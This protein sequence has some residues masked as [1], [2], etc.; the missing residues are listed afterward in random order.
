MAIKAQGTTRGQAGADDLAASQSA[1][2]RGRG[3]FWRSYARSKGAILGAVVLG[4]MILMAVFAT[5]VTPYDPIEVAPQDALAGPTRSH[6]MGTDQYGR[7]VFSR[8]ISG[9]RISLAIGF[10][11]VAIS[12]SVGTCLGVIAGFTENVVDGVIMRFIDMQLAFPG[13]LLAMAIVA[14]LGASTVNVVIAV[15]IGTIPVYARVARGAV[16]SIKR[17]AYIDAGRVIGCSTWRL[18]VRHI[19]PNIVA[20]I[21]VLATIGVAYSIINGSALAFLGLGTQPPDAEWGL[22]ISDGRGYLNDAWWISTFP[23]LAL[24]VVVLAINLVGDGLRDTFD[25]RLRKR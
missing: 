8:V 9:S 10:F 16:L 1:A 5:W 6:L 15:G 14:A 11:A 25:P 21:V 18:I 19:L 7:D 4:L 24:A 17:D 23:G 20:P 12:V 22:M 13:I 2:G 3:G